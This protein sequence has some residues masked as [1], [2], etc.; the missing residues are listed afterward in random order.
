M[1]ILG[2]IYSKQS[3]KTKEQQKHTCDPHQKQAPSSTKE[4]QCSSCDQHLN[5]TKK[6][7]QRE[8]HAQR[9][10]SQQRE[11]PAQQPPY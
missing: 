6:V 5:Q 4:P 7:P 1:T 10:L 8:I 9:P 3:L 2:L 11:V